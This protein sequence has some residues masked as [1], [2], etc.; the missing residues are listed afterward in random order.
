[1]RRRD[2]V[3]FAGRVAITWP[4]VTARAQQPVT[5]VI[6]FLGSASPERWADRMQTFH[7]GLSEAGYVEGHNVTIEYRWA[8]G[9]N[10]QL[11]SLAADLVRRQVAV[12]AAPG[13]TP[14]AMAAKAATTTI[15][16]VFAVGADPIKVGLVASLSRPGGNLTGLTTL[17]A[18]L[19]PKQLQ[20]LHEMVPAATT[21]TLLINP[22]SPDLAESATRDVEAAALPLERQI[23]V[24][25]AS[26]EQDF[27]AVF[28]TLAQA[29]EG[30]LMIGPDA[31]YTSRAKELAGL[32][33]RHR[34]P[35]IAAVREFAIAG[36]LM[37]YG[38]SF[39]DAHRMAGIYTGRLLKGKTPADLPVEQ[40]VKVELHVNLKTAKTLGIT[41]PQSI[42]AR[43]DVVIE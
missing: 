34:I 19:G 15:P 9:H 40:S 36:G 1:V 30:A 18:E 39:L 17:T 25:R 3:K 38:G 12:I 4:V 14:A 41:V 43:A 42:L 31:F 23:R 27:D 20:L 22:T 2:L 24:L 32:A 11:A 26:T 8:E 16:I 29:S 28:S 37:S 10:D 33:L 6:G 35:A 7:Q 13:S 5:P 21:V